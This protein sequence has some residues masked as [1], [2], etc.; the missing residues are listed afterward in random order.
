MFTNMS[1]VG[2]NVNSK[3]EMQELIKNAQSKEFACAADLQKLYQE[4]L[5]Q[6]KQQ[7]VTELPSFANFTEVA[8]NFNLS[9][10]LFADLT[11]DLFIETLKEDAQKLEC[12]INWVNFHFELLI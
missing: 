7:E 10:E 6:K 12:C 9:Q 2:G 3:N 8:Y 11:I 4:Q 5:W 1:C